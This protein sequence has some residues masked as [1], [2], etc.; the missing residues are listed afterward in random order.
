MFFAPLEQFEVYKVIP[1]F[2]G[3]FKNFFHFSLTNSTVFTVLVLLIW[4][5]ACSLFKIETRLIP[6]NVQHLWES[7]LSFVKN[8]VK[9]NVGSRHMNDIFV[10]IFFTFCLVLFLNLA[11]M[12]PYSFTVTSHFVITFTLSA[13]FFVA[14]NVIALSLH[15]V[16]FVTLFIPEGAPKQL[17]PVLFI[18]EFI[19]YISRVFSLSIR[20]FANLMSGHTL[21][22]ILA[23]FAWLML[24]SG[25]LLTF[26]SIFPVGII[27]FVTILEFAI[28]ILQAYVFCMLLCLYYRE[29]IFL[30]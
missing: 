6:T 13:A 20:L 22:K 26:F 15:G 28:G 1:I 27:F 30:H 18:I 9:E 7:T 25:G 23:G 11:G 10:P 14:I 3:C 24:I 29:A 8:L 19:S 17:L 5:Q 12:I 4:M 2:L 21:L 16:K